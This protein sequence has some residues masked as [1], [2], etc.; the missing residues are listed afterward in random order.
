MIEIKEENLRKILNFGH[1]IG[2]AVESLF[3]KADKIIPH[4]E[5][6]ALGMIA[7]T[8][9]AF[10]EKLISEETAEEIIKNIR[11]F[12]PYISIKNFNFIFYILF[13][14]LCTFRY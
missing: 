14:S 8:H 9:L 4:G 11:R 5:A 12:Y 2:H 7:E 10:L 3:L 13:A 6:V 1:T